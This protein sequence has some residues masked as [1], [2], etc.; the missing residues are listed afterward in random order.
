MNMESKVIKI[1]LCGFEFH[2]ANRG[3]EALTISFL[4]I[5]GKCLHNGD[6]LDIIVFNSVDDY[7]PVLKEFNFINS[8]VSMPFPGKKI[9]LWKNMFNVI[10]TCQ[11]F[12]DVTYGDSFSDI[13]GRN[14]LIKT[15][16]IKQV[17]LWS[18]TALILLPQTYGPYENCILRKWSMHIID[19]SSE[20]YSRDETSAKYLGTYFGENKRI[21][22]TTDLAFELP[23]KKNSIVLNRKVIN[24][25]LNVSGLLWCDVNNKFNLKFNYKDYTIQ[26]INELVSNRKYVIHIIPHVIDESREN[27]VDNDLIA[28]DEL[29]ELFGEKIIIGPPFNNAIEAKNYISQMDFFIGARMHSTIAAVSSNV[30][31]VAFSYSRKFEGLFGLLHYNYV[32]SAREISKKEALLKT[33]NYIEMRND[34]SKEFININKLIN[35]YNVQLQKEFK[36]ILYD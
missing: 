19:K 28:C 3:C 36:R 23:Y 6:K 17:V 13:Y 9:N 24:I 35:N 31:T 10:K 25:G 30:P 7:S 22:I 14:W 1:G 32:I 34:I 11:C 27:M 26:L 16:L 4:T 5:I 33:L 8:I 21:Y 18:K 2:R 15:N 12:F 20:V 29:G